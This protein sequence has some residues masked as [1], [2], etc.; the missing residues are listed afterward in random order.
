MIFP[1][2]VEKVFAETGEKEIPPQLSPNN[3]V[4]FE[5]GYT[6]DYELRLNSNN[7]QAKA[8]ER[9]IQNYLF[10][11]LTMNAKAWQSQGLPGWYANKTGGY[12]RNAIVLHVVNGVARPYRS[13]V[14]QNLATPGS[15]SSSWEYQ[16]T[17]AEM[18]SNIPMPAGGAAGSSAFLITT[19]GAAFNPTALSTGSYFFVTDAAA[20]ATAGLPITKDGTATERRAGLLEVL[21]NQTIRLARY[22]D[23]LGN[24]FVWVSGSTGSSG[25]RQLVDYRVMQSGEQNFFTASYPVNGNPSVWGGTLNPAPGNLYHG[26]RVWVQPIYPTFGAVTLNLNGTGA[27]SVVDQAG[28]EFQGYEFSGQSIYELSYDAPNS[29]WMLTSPGSIQRGLA[30]R[31][32]EQLP[33][34]GQV[35]ERVRTNPSMTGAI[36]PFA[37]LNPGPEWLRC[38]GSAYPR[39]GATAALFA[40]IG[41]TFGAGDGSTTFNVPNIRGGFIRDMDDRTPAQGGLDPQGPRNVGSFQTSDNLLHMHNGEAA[42]AGNH[43]HTFGTNGAGEH[44]HTGETTYSG[45]HI[46][47]LTGTASAAGVHGHSV[48]GNTDDAGTHSHT[49]SGN[50]SNNGSHQHPLLNQ[51]SSGSSFPS[52]RALGTE[53]TRSQFS[54]TDNVTG[55]L[56]IA[57]EGAH[58]H[59]VSGTSNAAGLHRH[60]I[61]GSTDQAGAHTHTVSGQTGSGNYSGS[62]AHALQTTSN[63]YHSHAGT[64]NDAGTHTHTIATDN[65]GGSESRPGNFTFPH[66]IHI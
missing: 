63:G 45:G 11:Q 14:N 50:T 59:D 7:P 61:Y 21:V 13:L 52:Q 64:T 56:L 27:K 4:N 2:V 48:S 36:Q 12:E 16:Q 43:A 18:I 60:N 24:Q 53:V 1:D 44:S 3:F 9:R 34:W 33:N 23:R 55:N 35:K 31:T 10:N 65:R 58:S 26:M 51:A 29:R 32:D 17:M 19:G 28:A 49:M 57:A 38:N 15:D 54:I 20:Q 8:V 6:A 40:A 30:A 5:T 66:F 46:H 41:T 39:T 37:H 22:T 42:A 62:H 47:D 25:W